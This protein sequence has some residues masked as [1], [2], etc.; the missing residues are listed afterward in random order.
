MH[1]QTQKNETENELQIGLQWPHSV[2]AKF[3]TL[4]RHVVG[5]HC[6]M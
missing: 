1:E 6:A 3:I 5:K 2:I 4:Q